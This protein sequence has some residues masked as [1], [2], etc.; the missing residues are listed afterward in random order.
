MGL[1]NFRRKE[2][3]VDVEAADFDE[4]ELDDLHNVP[5]KMGKG[6]SDKSPRAPDNHSSFSLGVDSDDDAGSSEQGRRKE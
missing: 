6:Y 5:K 1:D 4:R 3:R 2:R